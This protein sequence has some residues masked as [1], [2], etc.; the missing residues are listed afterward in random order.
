MRSLLIILLNL[1]LIS[2]VN[3]A[4]CNGKPGQYY[5]NEEPIWGGDSKL[6]KHH[7]YGQLH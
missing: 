1:L 6:L 5:T 7:K 2:L 3:N 4:Y